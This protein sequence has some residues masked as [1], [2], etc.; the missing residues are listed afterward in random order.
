MTWRLFALPILLAIASIVSLVPILA[1]NNGLTLG[2]GGSS[3]ELGEPRIEVHVEDPCGW[4]KDVSLK[5]LITPEYVTASIQSFL[6]DAPA[7]CNSVPFALFT[8]EGLALR[9]PDGNHAPRSFLL[10]KGPPVVTKGTLERGAG[11][12]SSFSVR[13]E[14]DDNADAR[15]DVAKDALS[16]G[17]GE[18][19]VL[20][21]M[22]TRDL[23][24]EGRSIAGRVVLLYASSEYDVATAL[25]STYRVAAGPTMASRSGDSSYPT[26]G[27]V[28]PV[29]PPYPSDVIQA[30]WTASQ[31]RVVDRSS[32]AIRL[33]VTV[34][35]SAVFGA[36]VSMFFAELLVLARSRP[37]P[38]TSPNQKGR[39]GKPAGQPPGEG[40]AAPLGEGTVR[41]PV[42]AAAA[43]VV[44][45][46]QPADKPIED[47]PRPPV[48]KPGTPE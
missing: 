39:V 36:F 7:K 24:P 6:V 10:S 13:L 35:G 33:F 28:W 47:P 16:V 19:A 26:T 15:F 44:G 14:G 41:K 46:A 37:K 5:L 43:E 31:V 1:V 48:E 32:V 21:Q 22:G 25:P 29:L 20:V 17:F 8:T 23:K 34:A 30:N 9:L 12:S 2:G 3:G 27:L 4:I 38:K 45:A 42:V 18:S 11:L 40:V